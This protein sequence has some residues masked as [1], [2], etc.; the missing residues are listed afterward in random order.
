LPRNWTLSQNTSAL[1]F[2]S[3]IGL[4]LISLSLR[5]HIWFGFSHRNWAFSLREP[6]F[7][8]F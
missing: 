2:C 8:L 7:T 1:A 4:S 3:E 6:I 5:E